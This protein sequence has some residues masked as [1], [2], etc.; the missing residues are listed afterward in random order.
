M[1]VFN[2]EKFDNQRFYLLQG[3]IENIKDSIGLNEYW[4]YRGTRYSDSE[5]IAKMILGYIIEETENQDQTR[6]YE[7]AN[8]KFLSLDTY[9]IDPYIEK[10]VRESASADY[11]YKFEKE[12]N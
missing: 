6:N 8:S 2:L 10:A 11:F 4:S 7:A 1:L 3:R 5:R 9:Q 12:M